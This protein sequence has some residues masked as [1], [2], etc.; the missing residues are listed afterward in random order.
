MEATL[1]HPDGGVC[2]LP[3]QEITV[4]QAADALLSMI[5]LG[6]GDTPLAESVRAQLA[7]ALGMRGT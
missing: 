3:T 4:G 1:D 5:E 6:R 2:A 7:D